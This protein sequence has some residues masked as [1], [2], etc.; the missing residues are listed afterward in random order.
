MSGRTISVRWN[1]ILPSTCLMAMLAAPAEASEQA[2]TSTLGASS[3]TPEEPPPTERSGWFLNMSSTTGFSMDE[4]S[5][6]RLVV[7]LDIGAMATVVGMEHFV[8]R[9][10]P[11]VGLQAGADDFFAAWPGL[12]AQVYGYPWGRSPPQV[13]YGV[14]LDVQ[15]GYGL[16]WEQACLARLRM[17]ATCISGR[18]NSADSVRARLNLVWTLSRYFEIIYPGFEFLG[19]TAADRAQYSFFAGLG[20]RF[21]L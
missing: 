16:I 7:E 8:V 12:R 1:R 19:G 4:G 15:V 2:D 6:R 14:G 3:S 17:G 20:W 13:A 9:V 10:G 11:E 5:I 21:G 18:T